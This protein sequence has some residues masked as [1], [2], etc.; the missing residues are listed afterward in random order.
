LVGVYITALALFE[1]E[2][3]TEYF[4]RDV[5]VN[6]VNDWERVEQD[7]HKMNRIVTIMIVG[8]YAVA[9]A[10]L[11]LVLFYLVG[12]G[13][14]LLS[15]LG[16]SGVAIIST[17]NVH[18]LQDY[19]NAFLPFI[20]FVWINSVFVACISSINSWS[21][22]NVWRLLETNPW[23]PFSSNA[24]IKSL[25]F[26]SW[27]GVWVFIMYSCLFW[28]ERVFLRILFQVIGD[29]SMPEIGFWQLLLKIFQDP[30]IIVYAAAL[31]GSFGIT[32]IIRNHQGIKSFFNSFSNVVGIFTM[33]T[34]KK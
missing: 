6:Y 10:I 4:N 18:G 7:V 2:T 23:K 17:P 13:A 22:L 15:I 29:G 34:G 30:M 25:G 28:E 32:S 14:G 20:R 9:Y 3:V 31:L 1:K 19:Y 27:V 12:I 11:T 24:R 8:F 26:M 33:G 5:F 16:W 21:R